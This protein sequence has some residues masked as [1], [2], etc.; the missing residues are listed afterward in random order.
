MGKR[1]RA[2]ITRLRGE[3][4]GASK[5]EMGG[6]RL[7]NTRKKKHRLHSLDV[8]RGKSTQES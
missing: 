5:D 3:G 2:Q 1:K 6:T 8:E 7:P 4:G